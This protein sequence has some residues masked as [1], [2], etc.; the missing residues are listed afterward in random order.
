[1]NNG[2]MRLNPPTIVPCESFKPRL[3]HACSQRFVGCAYRY[4]P[5]RISTHTETP[6]RPFGINRA[7]FVSSTLQ[8]FLSQI[9][10][11]GT[12]D[13]VVQQFRIMGERPA[14]VLI[15][16]ALVSLWAA[17]GVIKSLI[18]GFQSAYRVPRNRGFVGQ[19]GV[20]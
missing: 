9:V 18:E 14:A 20:A 4:L 2:A 8:D 13:L 16:A 5:S 17:S 1:M 7:E 10:P 11:P 3:A 6:S 12:E 19:S 15:V